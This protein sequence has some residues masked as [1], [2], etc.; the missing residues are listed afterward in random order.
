M[1]GP[2]ID[3]FVRRDAGERIAGDVADA[4]AAGLDAVH[5][6]RGQ[7]FHH[8][9]AAI[10]RDPV[11]LQVLARREVTVAAVELARD[12]AERAQLVRVDL[13]VRHRDPQHRRMALHVPAVLQAQRPELVV[14]ELAGQVAGQLVAVLGRAALHEQAVELGVL[15]HG[16][17]GRGWRSGA[18]KVPPS[19]HGVRIRECTGSFAR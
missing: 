5:V 4:V 7:R 18:A 9:G 12:A 16:R 8:V 11:E 13:A 6:D 17:W 19:R 15:V 2:R 3:D 10:E 14:A 1:Y